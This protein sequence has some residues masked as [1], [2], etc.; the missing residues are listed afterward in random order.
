[1]NER[2]TGAG[3]AAV[4]PEVQAPAEPVAPSNAK[5]SGRVQQLLVEYGVIGI[6]VLL[7]ISAL[8]YVG[9]LV[10]ILVGFEVDGADETAGA[11][12]AAGVAWLATKPIRIPLAIVLTPVVAQIWHRVRGK[13]RKP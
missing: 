5:P 3:E 4:E 1:M 10:A 13:A 6:I 11:F 2:S 12:A 9:I 8:T 7:S